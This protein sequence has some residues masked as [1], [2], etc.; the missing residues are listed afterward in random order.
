MNK[1]STTLFRN[2]YQITLISLEENK[3]KKNHQFWVWKEKKMEEQN[4]VCTNS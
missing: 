1:Y 2:D 4:F 3:G